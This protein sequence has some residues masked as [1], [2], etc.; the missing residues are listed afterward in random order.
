MNTNI[1]Y[2]EKKKGVLEEKWYPHK[3]HVITCMCIK[4]YDG[5]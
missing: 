1:G 2:W 4:A 5:T 3:F